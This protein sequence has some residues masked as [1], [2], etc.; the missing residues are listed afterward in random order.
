MAQTEDP[1]SSSKSQIAQSI[2]LVTL[3]LIAAVPAYTGVNADAKAE[4]KG[5]SG[6][7]QNDTQLNCNLPAHTQSPMIKLQKHGGDPA[8]PDPR[9]PDPRDEQ[10]DA[11]LP[12]NKDRNQGRAP[13]DVYGDQVPNG[14]T[15]Y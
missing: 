2:T 1:M 13:K 3:G 5:Q 7:L 10:H 15:P 12:A 11:D 9:G 6:K 14:R 4:V 8:G